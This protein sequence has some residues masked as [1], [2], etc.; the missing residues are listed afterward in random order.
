M[1]P[2]LLEEQIA[3]TFKKQ[4]IKY[5]RGFVVPDQQREGEFELDFYIYWPVRSFL[6][7]KIGEY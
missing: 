5:K 4:G 2:I 3:D 1:T 7:I 6:E